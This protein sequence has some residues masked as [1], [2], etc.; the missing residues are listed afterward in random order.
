MHGAGATTGIDRYGI[1]GRTRCV[2]CHG[3]DLAASSFHSAAH[4]DA[5][6]CHVCHA[7]PYKQCYGC[8]TQ[9]RNGTAYFTNNESDPTR[10]ARRAPPAWTSSAS[11]AKDAY[12]THGGVEYRSLQAS[13]VNHAPPD[14]A[15]WVAATAPLPAGDAL[16]TFRVGNNPRYGEPGAPKYA[17]LRHVPIDGETFAYTVDGTRI[18]GLVPDLAALPTWKYA[19]PHNIRRR[20]LIT[21]DPDGD[22]PATACGNCHSE[23][24]ESYWLTDPIAD[25][26]GWVPGDATWENAANADVVKL[27]PIDPPIP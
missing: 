4:V 6:S 18:D 13:N 19:T 7:Q 23:R 1:T 25:S 17:V 15:W 14:A 9:E 22:G 3:G 2:D 11:Y 20:T 10:A 24:F 21:T 16:I 26:F 5:M 8:H 12:V 27:S